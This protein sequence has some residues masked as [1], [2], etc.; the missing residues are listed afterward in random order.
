LSRFGEVPHGKV[1]LRDGM[2]C[3]EKELMQY[4]NCRLSVFKA[5]RAVDF[6]DQIPKTATGKPRRLAQDE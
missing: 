5:L 1:K 4:V 6:V 2:A 3:T